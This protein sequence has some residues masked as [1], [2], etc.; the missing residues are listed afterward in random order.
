MEADIT[1]LKN[2]EKILNDY[3]ATISPYTKFLLSNFVEKVTEIIEPPLQPRFGGF[4]FLWLYFDN[5]KGYL[6]NEVKEF[7]PNLILT[8]G[9]PAHR[10]FAALTAEMKWNETEIPM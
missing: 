1:K 5:C 10:L 6:I 4:Q 7:K 9:E 3:R 8:F 2:I